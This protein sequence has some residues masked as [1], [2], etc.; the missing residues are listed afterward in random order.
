MMSPYWAHRDPQ[1][2]PLPDSY[3]PVTMDTD[4]QIINIAYNVIGPLEIM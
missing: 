3:D 1:L 4:L 2:F